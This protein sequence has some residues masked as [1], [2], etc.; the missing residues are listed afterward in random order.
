MKS[1]L[2]LFKAIPITTKGKKKLDKELLE[3]TITK[4]FVFAP[5][6]LANYSEKEL[7]ELIKVV[8][9]EIGLTSEKLNASFHKSWQKIKEAN[10][11][12]LVIEQIAHY[13]T[14]YG[15]ESPEEYLEEK[16]VQ[17]EVD[18]LGKKV[19]GLEDFE[20]DKLYD[21]DYIYI[22]KEKL[23]I[24][25]IEIDNITLTII[26]GY[27]KQEFKDKLLKLLGSGIALGEDTINDV[28]DVATF[29]ELNEKEIE[30]IKNKEVK[31]ALY[32]YLGVFPENPIEF[33]RYIVYKS[34]GKTLLIKDS[35]TIETIKTNEAKNLQVLGLFIK[36]KNKHG[37]EKLS[38]IFY[39]FKPLFLAFKNGEQL[40]HTINKIRKLAKKHHKPMKEDYLN[41]ITAK[42]K[43]ELPI[44]A[45]KLNKELNRV[46][47][48]RKIRLAY[49]LN[50]RK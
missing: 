13:L 26:K 4:G 27:T 35:T 30:E 17:W 9:K 2:K 36:Y 38:T 29:V 40:N 21:Q 20:E 3:N 23:E 47:T 46:N 32:D 18:D 50:F 8:E 1:T 41:G 14:T 34:T 44:T 42:I 39:R 22:P 45:D 10:L 19:M 6:V 12:Q 43:K 28:I 7:T 15:K 5:E 11:E 25:D 48:F 31:V 16:E 37:L 24:P 49:S 33:L